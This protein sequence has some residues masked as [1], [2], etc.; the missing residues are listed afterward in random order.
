[1]VNVTTLL[2]HPTELLTQ[3]SE[4]PRAFATTLVNEAVNQI[5][6]TYNENPYHI[7]I[8]F[9]L[10][11]II[12]YLIFK[13]PPPKQSRDELTSEEIDEIIADFVPEPM[14]P[15]LTQEQREFEPPIIQSAAAA[16]TTINGKDLL[17]LG[18]YNFLGFV[19]NPEIEED[20]IK[21]LRKYGC[22]SCGPRGFYGTVDVHLQLE[23]NIAKFMKTPEAIIYAYGFATIS[24]A[25]PAFCKRGDLIV[26][27]QGVSLSV[28]TGVTLSRSNVICFKHNDVQDLERILKFVQKQDREHPKK[29]L[30]RRFIVIEGIYANYG[31]VAPL[32]EIVELKQKYKFRLCVEESFSFG[33][34]GKTGRGITEHFD[35]PISSIDITTASM[36]NAL[37]SVGGFCCGDNDIVDHQRLSGQ[38]YIFSASLPPY[39]AVAALKSLEILQAHPDIC[40]TLLQRARLFRQNIMDIHGLIITSKDNYVPMVHMTLEKSNGT[41]EEDEAILQKIVDMAAEE[42]IAITRPKYNLKDE[43]FLP[44]PS[45]R[46]TISAAHEEKELERAA[47]ILKKI[48][49]T[50]IN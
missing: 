41:R 1:M 2:V 22:G 37:G 21:A 25:I 34:L 47:S 14:V 16:H 31:D 27:D 50:V 45:I 4:N 23:E 29:E 17:N 3:F 35:V 38:G 19:G 30:N 42:G 8:E 13:K 15:P 20:A 12:F 6:K 46:V 43:K 49:K 11:G 32:R 28:Q 5:V 10:F 39:L 36:S 7:I 18:S 48:A 26:C 33:I 24:S 9:L 44:T 40:A